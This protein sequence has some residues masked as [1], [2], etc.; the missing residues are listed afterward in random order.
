MSASVTI[1]VP[2]TAAVELTLSGGSLVDI[3]NTG[4]V[5]EKGDAGPKG[6]K[7]DTG[8]TG[9]AGQDG[10]SAYEIAAA[11]GFVGTEAQWLASLEGTD[12]TD[13]VD[14]APANLN[15]DGT[16]AGAST[17]EGSTQAAIISY[18]SAK[19]IAMATSLSEIVAGK[20]ESWYSAKDITATTQQELPNRKNTLYF[21]LLDE[22]DMASNSATAGATQQS[23]KAYVDAQEAVTAT[24]VNAA[25]ATMNADT[26]VSGTSWVLD[27]DN[28]VSNSATKVPTQQSVK[29][30]VDSQ[31]QRITSPLNHYPVGAA[32]TLDASAFAVHQVSLETATFGVDLVPTLT[33]GNEANVVAYFWV[34]AAESQAKTVD[35]SAFS[36][37]SSDGDALGSITVNP[38]GITEVVFNRLSAGGAPSNVFAQV[39]VQ[40]NGTAP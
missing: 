29:A 32:V 26:D 18:V 17:T 15:N 1:E 10:D 2:G 23:I 4:I 5:G 9:P 13:G 28:M 21:T 25:G 8:D 22:D 39:N 6:D 20:A 19:T 37:A 24:T 3:N 12:G 33:W 40:L 38:G 35:L 31:V 14:G 30:Y 36:P 11:N 27:E 16:L 7:G 34:P